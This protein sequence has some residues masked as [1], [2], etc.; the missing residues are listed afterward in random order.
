[1][2]MKRINSFV[3]IFSATAL[4]LSCKDDEPIQP[5][6]S[7]I[8]L[9]VEDASCTEAWL[10]VSLTDANEPRTIGLQRDGQTVLTVRILANDTTLTDEGL[11][12]QHAYS[13]SAI[14]LRDVTVIDASSVVQ[15]TTQDTS[16]HTWQFSVDTLGDGNGSILRDVAIVN[17]TTIWAVGQINFRDSGGTFTD[18]PYNVIRWNGTGWDFL[19]L[20]FPHYNFDCS[21]A[22]YSSTNAYAI[23]AFNGNSILLSNGGSVARWNGSGLVHYPCIPNPTSG[24]TI[25]KLWGI[26]ENNFYA[27]CRS[28]V[29]L[30]YLNGAWQTEANGTTIDLVDVWGTSQSNVWIAG[31]DLTTGQRSLILHFDGTGWQA[32]YE[33]D[34]AIQGRRPDSLSGTAQSVWSDSK[35]RAFVSTSAA[36]YVAPTN[37][38]GE[39]RISW[40]PTYLIG[41][42]WRV[43]ASAS[44]NVFVVGDF[45]TLAHFSGHTWYH[46]NQFMSF[47]DPLSLRSVAVS[48][49]RVCATGFVG[50]R[51]I[52]FR[53]KKQ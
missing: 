29:I 14:R 46:F 35:Y 27:V 20:V 31:L 53:G 28:G 22:F 45:G 25:F 24:N 38:R 36:E 33:Y 48:N 34:P 41:F 9:T 6:I 19:R 15:L 44:N 7:T 51:G 42:L 11:L 23:H 32:L 2:L 52:A 12:P 8:Q 5:H 16:S 26:S 47:F 49:T 3:V 10:K 1:M 4:L 17:D 40:A 18:P 43:R 13:Y 21:I 39:G 37:T 50:G 30:H